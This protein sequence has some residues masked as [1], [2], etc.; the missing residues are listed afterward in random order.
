MSLAP[1]TCLNCGSL[2]ARLATAKARIADLE[3]ALAEARTAL[4]KEK[5][6]ACPLCPHWMHLHEDGRCGSGCCPCNEPSAALT[7]EEFEDA[8][9]KP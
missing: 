9:G 4:P 7:A 6:V 3:V 1:R 8:E 2:R 5:Y